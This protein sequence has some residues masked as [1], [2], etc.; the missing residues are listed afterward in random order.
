VGHATLTIT[1]IAVEAFGHHHPRGFA[2]ITV[3]IS[4]MLTRFR[5]VLNQKLIGTVVLHS[6]AARQGFDRWKDT[7]QKERKATYHWEET[8]PWFW[9]PLQPHRSAGRLLSS[10]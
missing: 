9:S 5:D 4:W 10:L 1:P 6:D 2:L 8:H 3:I 7:L